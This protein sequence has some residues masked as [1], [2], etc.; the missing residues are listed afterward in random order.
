MRPMYET[1]DDLANENYIKDLLAIAWD[2]KLHKLPRSYYVD[3]MITK[4][5][6]AKGFAELKCRNNDRC[7]YPTLMLSMHKWMHGKELASEIGGSFI[8]IVRWNDGTFYHKQGSCDVT[9][10]IGG[11]TDRGDNQDIEPVVYIPT[12]YFKRIT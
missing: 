3:W 6:E 2:A 11:R 10:G 1:Q 9:Y 12:D 4:K 8:I 7:K 5:G